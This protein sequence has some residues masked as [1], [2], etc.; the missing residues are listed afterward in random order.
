MVDGQQIQ[1]WATQSLL[2]FPFFVFVFVFLI[3]TMQTLE[4]LGSLSFLLA[5]EICFCFSVL[6][7]ISVMVLSK[8]DSLSFCFKKDTWWLSI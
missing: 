6:P 2:G 5:P 4:F 1:A 3:G 8:E 7:H